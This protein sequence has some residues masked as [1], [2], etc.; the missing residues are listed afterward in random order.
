MSDNVLV[1]VDLYLATHD[2]VDKNDRA[3]PNGIYRKWNNRGRTVH[4]GQERPLPFGLQVLPQRA[5]P[6]STRVPFGTHYP[7][8]DA[9]RHYRIQFRSGRTDRYHVKKIIAPIEIL[10]DGKHWGY[11]DDVAIALGW[12]NAANQCF[13]AF[14]YQCVQ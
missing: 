14:N 13:S 4:R 10:R 11:M 5:T 12:C 7:V 8:Q 2:K 1:D 3:M 9:E 6:V